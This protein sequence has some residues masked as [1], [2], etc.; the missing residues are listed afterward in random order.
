MEK[1]TIH[2]SPKLI[3]WVRKNGEI[4]GAVINLSLFSIY[5]HPHLHQLLHEQVK[6]VQKNTIRPVDTY[7]I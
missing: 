7:G 4:S 2:I 6:D 5:E 1:V 3:E